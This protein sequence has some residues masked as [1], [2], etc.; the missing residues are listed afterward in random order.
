M[1]TEYLNSLHDLTSNENNFS[2]QSAFEAIIQRSFT[3]DD[4]YQMLIHV[5]RKLSSSK[6]K[7]RKLLKTLYL[8]DGLV[9]GGS[10]QAVET[11]K[12]KVDLL[13][14]LTRFTCIEKN[15]ERGSKSKVIGPLHGYRSYF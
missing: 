5:I 14:N 4:C 2:D 8:I 15:I 1:R 11:I 9:K 6:M 13:D 7:W 12:K 10:R 3:L